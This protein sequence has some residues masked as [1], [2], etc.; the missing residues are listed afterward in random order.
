[1]LEIINATLYATSKD[2]LKPALTGVYLNVEENKQFPGY[3]V[4]Q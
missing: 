1:M 3:K 2:D 4:I